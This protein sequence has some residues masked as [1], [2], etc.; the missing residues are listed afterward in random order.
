MSNNDKWKNKK[1]N[2]K[3]YVVESGKP[4]R[5]LSRS[6][7]IALTGLFL[8]VIPSFIMFLI[9]GIDGWIIKS[10]KNLSRWGVEFPIAL[11]IAAI[12]IIIVLLL[13]FKFKVI[14]T[15]ALTFLI[16]ISLAINSFLVSS[17][18]RP[19]DWYIRVLPAVG[20]VFLAIPIILINKAVAKSQEKQ[21]KIKLLEEE[22]KNKSLL[23]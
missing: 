4:K 14:N 9:L 16:R 22:Q 23:D 11:A 17:G 5:E 3:N 1:V 6:W 8:I 2:L 21:R 7:K 12:Q 20:L 18:Q 10:T 15:E 13:V 19:E